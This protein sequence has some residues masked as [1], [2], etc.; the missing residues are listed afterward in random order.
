LLL[1]FRDQ[2]ETNVILTIPKGAQA[3]SIYDGSAS[4]GEFGVILQSLDGAGQVYVSRELGRLTQK[5][6][7]NGNPGAG[8][9]LQKSTVVTN[10]PS[11]VIIAPCSEPLYAVNTG[12]ADSLLSVEVF[13]L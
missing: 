13:K 2:G 7:A 9:F 1:S 12:A 4:C 3:Q 11:M 8:I 10:V 5:A 6:D